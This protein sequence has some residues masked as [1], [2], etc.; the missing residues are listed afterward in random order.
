MAKL[1][2]F[3]AVRAALLE[4]GAAATNEEVARHVAEHSGYDFPDRTALALYISMVN[5]KMNR[6]S[7]KD[8]LPSKPEF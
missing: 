8:K 2:R 3:Q 5:S 4:L 7:N 1:T 6:K